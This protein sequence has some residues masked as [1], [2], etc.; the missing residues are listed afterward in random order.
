LWQYPVLEFIPSGRVVKLGGTTLL[1]KLEVNNN[2]EGRVVK[3][4]KKKKKKLSILGKSEKTSGSL[5]PG[6]NLNSEAGGARPPTKELPNFV[7][8]LLPT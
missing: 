4:W 8:P 3:A 5:P 6:I 7:G 1:E 2:R